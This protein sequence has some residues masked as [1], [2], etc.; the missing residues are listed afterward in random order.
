MADGD[1]TT[2]P[3]GPPI[4]GGGGALSK[5]MMGLPTWG[6][7][8][9]AAAA[10][11]GI[12]VYLEYRRKST[13]TAAATDDG[14]SGGTSDTDTSDTQQAILAQLRDLQGD[15]STA[16]TTTTLTAPTGLKFTT[17]TTTH[18]V[19]TWAPLTGAVSYVAEWQDRT[20]KAT[21]TPFTASTGHSYKLNKGDTVEVR[22]SGIDSSGVRGPSTSASGVIK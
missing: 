3:G 19:I 22:V 13:P 8:A 20:G 6:W 21:T 15:T 10:G 2:R 1:P 7:I 11:I 14:T 9:I 5:K 17:L 18:A 4:T 16:T 12:A